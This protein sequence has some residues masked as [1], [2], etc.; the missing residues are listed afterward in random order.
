LPSTVP[1]RV[2]WAVEALAF[3]AGDRVLEIGCG[4]G[5]AAALV[6]PRLTAGSMVAATEELARVS[7][8]LAPGGKLFL[9]YELRSAA[10]AQEVA[11]RIVAVLQAGG[12]VEPEILTPA[13]TRLCCISRPR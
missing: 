11:Q 8:A 1:E 3:D 9:F 4:P 2:R 12:F 13:A 10:R 6:C 7:R 5:V